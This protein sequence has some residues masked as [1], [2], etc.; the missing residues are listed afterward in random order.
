MESRALVPGSAAATLTS[1]IELAPDWSSFYGRLK[2]T[3][4]EETFGLIS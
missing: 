4:W 1:R 3:L 2:K